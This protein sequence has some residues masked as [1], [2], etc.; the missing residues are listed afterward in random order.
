[1]WNGKHSRI[2]SGQLLRVTAHHTKASATEGQ[3]CPL[4]AKCL[5]GIWLHARI[6]R[7]N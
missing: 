7:V 2:G 6:G 4:E 1:M 5:E 3:V